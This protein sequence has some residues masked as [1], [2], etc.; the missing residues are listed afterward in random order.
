[1]TRSWPWTVEIREIL[2]DLAQEGRSRALFV[3]TDVDTPPTVTIARSERKT[4]DL[5]FPV[6][7][8][9]ADESLL[10]A[11]DVVWEVTTEAR[12]IAGRTSFHA[13]A[14]SE[15]SAPPST[16][17]ALVSG[18]GSRWWFHP[19]WAS[20]PVFVHPRPIVIR[21]TPGRVIVT[22]QP[23][24]HYHPKGLPRAQSSAPSDQ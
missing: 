18:W 1:M 15:P 19:L 21:P 5:Y 9:A 20:G 24:W 8:N 13:F 6:P 10:P 12:P 11:F 14:I 17:V 4:L 7:S 23:R 22:R 3:N 2:L 16:E